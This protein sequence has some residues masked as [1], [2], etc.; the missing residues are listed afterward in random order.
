MELQYIL[1]IGSTPALEAQTACKRSLSTYSSRNL[2]KT[3]LL[4]VLSRRGVDMALMP[5]ID[6]KRPVPPTSTPTASSTAP[7]SPA[8]RDEV[9]GVFGVEGCTW[10]EQGVQRGNRRGGIYQASHQAC[11]GSLIGRS[12]R[13]PRSPSSRRARNKA[14]WGSPNSWAHTPT[15][16]WS[17]PP[18]SKHASRPA[19]YPAQRKRLLARSGAVP[20]RHRK[21]I[22][23]QGGLSCGFQKRLTAT[24]LSIT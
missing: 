2:W 17:A 1:S 12:G 20:A 21:K 14:N 4:S 7:R 19:A 23:A 15:A 24:N 11:G 6:L 22:A 9:L 18:A 5:D 10:G 16:S 3:N 8:L 13:G